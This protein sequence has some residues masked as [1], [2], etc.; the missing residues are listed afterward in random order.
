MY[1]T[2]I[3]CLTISAAL[4]AAA[5]DNSGPRRGATASEIALAREKDKRVADSMAADAKTK[6]EYARDVRK[7]LD[8]FDRMYSEL[9]DRARR[10]EGQAKLELDAKVAHAKLKH[11]AASKKLDELMFASST[12]WKSAQAEMA[13]ALAEVNKAF[14]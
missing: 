14:E 5:C 4:L 12:R 8:Q 1:R 11:N 9:N 2:G 3:T 7:Q 10:A 6:D 13:S